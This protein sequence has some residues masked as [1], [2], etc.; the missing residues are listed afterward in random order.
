MSQ[1]QA[2]NPF[3]VAAA[4]FAIF[5]VKSLQSLINSLNPDPVIAASQLPGAVEVLVGQV[6]MQ[7]PSLAASE[8]GAVKTS[9][10]AD[11]DGVLAKLG[12][13]GQPAAA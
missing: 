4:P 6:K 5:V 10:S 2:P 11:L 1:N 3:E 7:F 8:F 12:T 9:V 13:I